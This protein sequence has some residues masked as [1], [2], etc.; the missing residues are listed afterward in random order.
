MAEIERARDGVRAKSLKRKRLRREVGI[1]A[2][3]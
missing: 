1:M 3:L 2:Q